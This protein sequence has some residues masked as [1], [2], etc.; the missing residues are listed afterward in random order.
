MAALKS[1]FAPIRKHPWLSAAAALLLLVFVAILSARLWIA[2]D[3]GRAWLLSQ[4]D[5]RKAGAYGT[6]DAEGL[7]GDPLGKMY[8][9]RLAVRDATG[10][11]VVAQNVSVDWSPMALV[12]G[13]V[14][15]KALSAGQ[16]D[17]IRRPVTE[18]Q[19]PSKGGSMDIRIKLRSLSIPD[20]TFEEGFA[21]PEAH[22]DVT[23]RYDQAGRTRPRS[24]SGACAPSPLPS[25]AA[26]WG[27]SPCRAG[28]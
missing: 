6:I 14:D 22:F 3:S 27:R 25:A 11:W 9:R 24:V 23:G 4:I 28:W 20:L 13:L 8:L 15:V 19:P 16:I 1:L 10:D 5:G 18:P 17:F 26:G 2:S 7:S 12:S 21:G